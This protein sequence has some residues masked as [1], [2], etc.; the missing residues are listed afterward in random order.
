[1]A[2]PFNIATQ[3]YKDIRLTLIAH[4]PSYYTG[5]NAKRFRVGGEHSIQTIW[6]P[7]CCLR[8]DGT[9]KPDVNLDWLFNQEKNKIKL[10]YAHE[11]NNEFMRDQ[12][13]DKADS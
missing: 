3:L 12:P 5:R 4:H 13:A 9:L 11:L 2:Y 6:I 10:R 7:N 1:M 8:P